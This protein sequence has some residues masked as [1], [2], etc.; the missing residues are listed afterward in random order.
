MNTRLLFA[1]MGGLALIVILSA[2]ACLWQGC[3]NQRVHHDAYTMKAT[4]DPAIPMSQPAPA[5]KPTGWV[6][7]EMKET[8]VYD[9]HKV[10]TFYEFKADGTYASGKGYKEFIDNLHKE[11]GPGVGEWNTIGA[12]GWE[13][14][15]LQNTSVGDT[16]EC[17]YRFKRPAKNT[18]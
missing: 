6:Y 12:V 13:F 17:I 18:P 4:L 14:V 3:S 11:V 9:G 5:P 2:V 1:T 10:V 16:R 8:S 7:A 15:A